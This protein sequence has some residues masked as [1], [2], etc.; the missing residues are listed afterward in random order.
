M[1]IM[2]QG[3]TIVTISYP[4]I[5]TRN[6]LVLASFIGLDD[7]LGDEGGVALKAEEAVRFF[8]SWLHLFLYLHTLT[9]KWHGL[10]LLSLD[11]F[12]SCALLADQPRID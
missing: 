7:V 12:R 5:L 6:A 4:A 8:F 10:N 2:I 3:G 1:P 11:Q 9:K